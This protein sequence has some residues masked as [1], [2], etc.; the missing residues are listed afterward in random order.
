M[1]AGAN[2]D[3]LTWSAAR[4]NWWRVQPLHERPGRPPKRATHYRCR[5]QEQQ[6][7]AAGVLHSVTIYEGLGQHMREI[8]AMLCAR[9]LIDEHRALAYDQAQM[10]KAPRP[11]PSGLGTT[12]AWQ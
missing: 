8:S 7:F 10:S 3:G 11:Q 12:R 6:T 4:E 1:M 2:T 5:S 9:G